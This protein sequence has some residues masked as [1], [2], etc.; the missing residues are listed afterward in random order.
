MAIKDI[1][2]IHA[3]TLHDVL[4]RA[5]RVAPTKGAAYDRAQGIHF[6]FSVD[7]CEVRA[8]NL[9]VTFWQNV[10]A[11]I[12][13]PYAEAV[14]MRLPS[15]MLVAFVASLPMS[16]EQMVRF[17]VD[18][19]HPKQVIIKFANTK[20]QAKM[21]QIVGSYPAFGP[22]P[23]DNMT[24]AQELAS[25]LEQVAWA[26]GDTGVLQGVLIDGTQIL[27]MDSKRAARVPCEIAVTEPVVAMLTTLVPL[28]KLGTDIRIMAEDG[29]V[30]MALDE[31]CQV[32]S[33]V[34]LQPYPNAI[35][36]LSQMALDQ[37]FTINKTRLKEALSRLLIGVRTD[38][39]PRAALTI[40]DKALDMRMISAGSGEI[41]D[42]AAITEQV[43][44][45]EEEVKFIF[46]PAT[47]SEA[48]DTFPGSSVKVRYGGNRQPWHL[49]GE[50]GYESWVMC[51]DPSVVDE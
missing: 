29:K 8:T 27:A 39:Q 20:L 30:Y 28:V 38:R 48:L 43:L 21:N 12:T 13:E 25:K 16:G 15:Q 14:E 47:L 26:T 2:S 18:D 34:I 35:E 7:H 33:T 44:G 49:V 17:R 40:K 5:N 23:V 24:P 22:R 36:R 51:I 50:D 41:E 45:T 9:D 11:N 10:P 37:T 3:A 46:N 32:T 19:E 42:S 1:A 4:Q 31:S 6:R